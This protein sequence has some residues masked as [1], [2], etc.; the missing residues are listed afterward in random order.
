MS[1][2]D[3]RTLE[4]ATAPDQSTCNEVFM[5]TRILSIP[6]AFVAIALAIAPAH[7]APVLDGGKWGMK[8]S[9]IDTGQTSTAERHCSSK[10]MESIYLTPPASCTHGPMPAY[11]IKSVSQPEL[12]KL[13]A[14]ATGLPLSGFNG[15]RVLEYTDRAAGIVYIRSDIAAMGPGVPFY[16]DIVEHSEAHMRGCEHRF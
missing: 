10:R 1:L 13:L 15:I 11:V 3:R 6:A 9:C 4:R 12:R 8:M 7:A 2:W 14:K 5:V 16:D